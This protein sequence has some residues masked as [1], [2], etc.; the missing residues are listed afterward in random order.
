MIT[1]DQ[2]EQ[3]CLDWFKELGYQYQNGYD[4]APDG[5]TPERE[6]Y[7][8]VTLQARL[9]S[10]LETLNPNVPSDTLIE[11]AKT[12]A[13]PQTPVLIKNNK[14]FHQYLIEGVPVEYSVMEQEQWV[15]KHTHV[16]LIDF[17]NRENNEFLVV[18]QFTITGT[19]VNRRP[20]VIVFI[21]GL[22]M[23][24]IELKNPADDHADIWNAYNQIQTYKEEIADLFVFNEALVIS[25]GWT[26]RVGSLTANKER[27]LPWK[28]IES[29][30]DKPLLEFQL[31]TMVRGFFKPDLL[32]DYIRYFVLFEN[33]G[34]KV[35]KKIAG[36]H[37]FHAVRAAV[38][39]TVI[40]ATT[41]DQVTEPRANYAN[42]VVPGSKKAGV[43][44]HTQG[45]GKSISMV[46]YASKLLQQPEMNNP[47][48][49]V[50]TDRND[51]DGQLFNTF[52]M[53]QETLKQIPQQAEDRDS[54]RDLLLN[55]QSGGIIF[56]TVQKFALLDEE[57]V[58]PVLSERS[59]IV[60]VSDEAHRSQYGNKAR[61][62]DVKDENGNVIDQ[63]YVYGYS[64]YMRDAL[65]NAA[66]IGFT[67]TPISM[68][69]KDTRGVFGDYVSIYDIQDAV[70]DGATVPIYYESRLAKLDINQDE[71]E[72]LND[73]VEEEIGED[74]ETASREKIKSHWSA[75]EKLVGAEPRIQQVAKDLVEHFTTRCETFPGKA[76]IVAM[77][78]EICVDLYDAIVA[79]KPEWHSD[80]P[81]KGAIKIIM[82]GSAADK[83][84]MQ[85]HIHDK[86][87]KKL[88]EKRYKDTDD[89]LQLVIVRDMWL[90]GFDAPC[91]HT[92]YID[93][94]MKGHNL[95]QAIAR[96]NRVFKDKP[97]GLVVDYIGIANELKNALKTY[98]NSQGKG[99]PTVDTAEAF[100]VF[101]EKIDVIRGMF[102]TPVD[103]DIF[104]YRPDFETKP[105]QLLPGA[106]NHISGLSHRNSKGE[107]C[108]DG[109]RRFLDVMAAL[110]KAFSLCNTL[111]EVDGYK[112][113]IAFYGAIKTAFLKH[114][115]VDK[116]R[117]D[118]LR[119]SALRQILNNAIVA[120]GVDDIFKT[121]GLDKPNIG[122]LSPE[123][124]EDVANMKEKNLAVE[125]LE[126]LLRDEVK[127]RMKND[128]VQEKK[129]SER[130]MESLRKYHNR[131]IE[132]A[133]VI[134]E[135]IRWAKEMQADADMMAKLN[136]S[137]D[138]IA[139]YRALIA[140]EASVRTLGDDNLRQLAIELTHQLRQSATVDWQKR[141]SV[142][143]RMRN[144]VRRLL[145]RWKYPPDAAEEAIKL[146]L[147][148]AEVLADGWYK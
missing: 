15:T 7:Q 36:Y 93:K 4:I 131:S 104:N 134:E 99:K 50:V 140:N 128:V 89:E 40:A 60:V 119:N 120:D 21:N 105:L 63:R 68:D 32:L 72:A 61:L 129:Y 46:C 43:V 20:D 29:E 58:H 95:M 11:V 64:K 16:R 108:R 67:G 10:A 49:V 19:K 88:F 73:Q 146:V 141:E 84:K 112:S 38:K 54:L 31:E 44:W 39:A 28:T 135:L 103:G 77:S 132:T 92:M 94:P 90:T 116:K 121:V 124:L 79:I 97:G 86:K 24:V 122:L 66:F 27:F 102:A 8:Q 115:T 142:R 65:P 25:D 1:E 12:V 30:D 69:D 130:I 22:P 143:A 136:L 91:C 137:P 9:V 110:M 81:N 106:V 57:M 75:L 14:L 126:K 51:L 6:N 56:T 18:N 33:D 26:A 55:R 76:M 52:T 85:P 87:T 82:T 127:A 83:A 59:N 17:D 144:L 114:S 45:S 109:K 47:T 138:E 3:Q 42:T 35:I 80:D 148:Q 113:E 118:E 100:A 62:V 53:A 78:R 71:I 147:D 117:S 145:R 123:F 107:E 23:A 139:F 111:D 41:S 2:L 13:T 5:D 34:D 70:D 133:Q 96:V 98:T 125:L 74:E 48:L 37:Q 101:M